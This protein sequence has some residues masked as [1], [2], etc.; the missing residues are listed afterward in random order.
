[1]KTDNKKWIITAV[2]ALALFAG[3]YYQKSSSGSAYVSSNLTL[4]ADAGQFKSILENSN[5][6]LLVIDLYA[7]WCAP[8]KVIAPILDN[9]AEKYSG[10]ADFY[11]VNVDQ[12]SAV[13]NFFKV[14]AIPYVVYVKNGVVVDALTGANSAAAYESKI[15]KNL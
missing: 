8:C 13:A 10:N 11:R 5:D 9:L 7:D 12:N 3:L 6:R 1:M 15:T 4:I 14:G 2:I